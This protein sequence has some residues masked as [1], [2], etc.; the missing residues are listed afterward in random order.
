[1]STGC[2]GQN[3]CGIFYDNKVNSSD[4]GDDSTEL[5]GGNIV[6]HSNPLRAL[7]GQGHRANADALTL[8]QLQPVAAAALA[9]WS[10]AG[11]SQPLLE[12]LRQTEVR[13]AELPAGYLGL[14]SIGLNAPSSIWISPNAAGHGWDQMDLLS[15]VAHEMGN[16]VGLQDTADL[17]RVM[18]TFLTAGVRRLPEAQDLGVAQRQASF[19][20]SSVAIRLLDTASEAV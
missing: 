7:A 11:L 4:A 14:S 16:V 1:R 3:G 18:G 17:G 8:A 9:R 6:I 12:V 15:V 5:G 10:A 2:V 20:N 19:L 13:I